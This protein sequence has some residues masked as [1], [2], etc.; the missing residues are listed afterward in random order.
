MH[1]LLVLQN[2]FITLSAA[3]P[4]SNNDQSVVS[5]ATESE[6]EST[7]V[8]LNPIKKIALE[9]VGKMG[10]IQDHKDNL[11]AVGIPFNTVNVLVEMTIH[12]REEDLVSM[13]STAVETS[14]KQHGAGGITEEKLARTLD[15]LAG[16]EKDLG[17]VRRLG[18]QQGL[19]MT[20]VNHL[21]MLIRLSPGDGGVK[22]VNTL[23][24]YALACD[25]PL[26]KVTELADE[27]KSGPAS[28]LP[29]IP[30]ED[31]LDLNHAARKQLFTDVC[32]GFFMAFVALVLLT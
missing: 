32:I 14:R 28:V 16:L 19:N 29:D 3:Q 5:V 11:M 26:D 6:A 24:A 21:T 23:L 8:P 9:I 20:A 12:G 18:Q 22:V 13:R 31:E 4:L 17:L 2:R 27:I 30:R 25:I 7:D 15:S 10:D 1:L